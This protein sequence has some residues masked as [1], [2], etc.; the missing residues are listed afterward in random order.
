MAFA[1]FEANVAVE[2]SHEGADRVSLAAQLHL[3]IGGQ[4]PGCF[5]ATDF[6]RQR[7]DA[8]L[9]GADI[10]RKL[11]RLRAR[12]DIEGGVKR[13]AGNL[14]RRL[15]GQIPIVEPGC[16]SDLFQR[17]LAR[18]QTIDG[19]LDLAVRLLKRGQR[20]RIVRKYHSIRWCLHA[21]AGFRFIRRRQ[22][23]REIDHTRAQLGAGVRPFSAG[24]H[25][26]AAGQITVTNLRD[27][28]PDLDDFASGPDIRR[29]ADGS[30]SRQCPVQL[31]QCLRGQGYVEVGPGIADDIQH[32]TLD[33]HMGV[34]RPRRHM[35]RVEVE[36]AVLFDDPER[37]V[38][39]PD[40]FYIESGERAQ[41]LGEARLQANLQT[42]VLAL[43]GL[44]DVA[45][46][47]ES[48]FTE[49][50][51]EIHLR[52]LARRVRSIEA[53][54]EILDRTAHACIG[55]PRPRRH[56]DIV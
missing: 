23:L 30:H 44:S 9:V 56:F 25:G 22:E 37:E 55:V 36:A 2:S 52:R 32:G 13:T 7:T 38:Q 5:I 53:D 51:L 1:D 28:I 31:A 18:D 16:D 50:A 49:H 15:Y 4:T 20:Q 8:D 33:R 41:R 10:R 40:L 12:V 24:V 34:P 19:E 14:G 35:D 29:Y 27:E 17:E 11:R 26:G 47:R 3:Q 6:F 46:E 21:G 45:G 42:Q 48:G 39:R 54:D 43:H